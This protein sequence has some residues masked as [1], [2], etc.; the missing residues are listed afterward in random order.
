VTALWAWERALQR[1]ARHADH[2]WN[3]ALLLDSLVGAG[4]AAFATGQAG[5]PAAARGPAT[6]R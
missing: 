6:L 3:E 2:P 1:V 5:A 4:R